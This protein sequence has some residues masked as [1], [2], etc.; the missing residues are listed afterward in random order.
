[1]ERAETKTT[2]LNAAASGLLP[3]IGLETNGWTVGILCKKP[4][5]QLRTSSPGRK[6]TN[7]I[8]ISNLREQ[9]HQLDH[10]KKNKQSEERTL[11]QAITPPLIIVSGLTPKLLGC[12]RTKSASL[13]T[14]MSPMTCDMPCVIAL[15]PSISSS[16][17]PKPKRKKERTG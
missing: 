8:R 1:M 2:E 15:P 13:P 11:A 12:Q 6:R 3:H 16:S 10:S 17:R 4:T 7:A 14:A 9:D 5:Y